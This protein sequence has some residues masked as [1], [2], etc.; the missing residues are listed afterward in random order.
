MRLDWSSRVLDAL[1][2]WAFRF[3][4]IGDVVTP[5]RLEGVGEELLSAATAWAEQRDLGIGGGFGTEGTS[6]G[7][8]C[9]FEFGLTATR[10]GQF[11][12]RSDAEALMGFI[13]HMAT[14]RG[15]EVEGGFRAYSDEEQGREESGG[16]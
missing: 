9:R 12:Q 6:E 14:T 8:V 2:E 13:S 3:G 4:V 11:I 5:D 1:V 7:L 16:K 10:D 15:C